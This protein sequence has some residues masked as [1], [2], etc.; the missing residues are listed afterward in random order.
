LKKENI[1]RFS[2]FK[3][4][5]FLLDLPLIHEVEPRT[6]VGVTVLLAKK[7]NDD[8]NYYQYHNQSHRNLIVSFKEYS[9]VR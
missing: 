8:G 2:D 4:R 6:R 9:Q 1:H 3:T 7:Q 5:S